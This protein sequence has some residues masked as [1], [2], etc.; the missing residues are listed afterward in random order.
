MEAPQT[1]LV[2]GGGDAGGG[3]LLPYSP[4]AAFAVVEQMAFGR[5]LH[6][7]SEMPG[8]PPVDSFLFWLS[9]TPDLQ[10]A[11]EKA[12]Q[13]SAY[14][15]E[16]EALSLTRRAVSDPGDT[17]ALRALELHVKQLQWSSIK[18][19]PQVYSEKSAVSVTVPIQINTS[20]DLGQDS[21]RKGTTEF[22]NIYAMRAENVIEVDPSE[23]VPVE[24]AP[25]KGRKRTLTPPP[26][27]TE[28][29]KRQQLV[30]DTARQ[31][32]RRQKAAVA[33]TVK[34]AAAQREGQP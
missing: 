12:R 25:A 31:A 15:M 24:P 27:P 22:P 5:T 34:A 7:I 20:L 14:V 28:T 13:M 18:R 6:E 21:A 10:L 17:S 32:A 8:M 4:S 29:E 26:P 1:D 11:V 30:K 33:R 23:L 2:P 3:A 16:D 9:Q 19:N